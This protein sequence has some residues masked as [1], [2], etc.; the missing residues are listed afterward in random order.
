MPA[1]AKKASEGLADS[2]PPDLTA[3]LRKQDAALS[4]NLNG[5]KLGRKGRDTR[6]RILAAAAEILG[7][8]DDLPISMTS[9]ARRASLGMTSLYNYFSDL[10]ELMLAVL[11]PV[12]ETAHA[13]YLALLGEYWP[14]EHLHER[15]IEFVLAYHNFWARNSRLLH[16]RNSMADQF[17]ARMVEQRIASTQ[18]VIER[19]LR[20]MVGDD[21]NARAEA[22]STAAMVMIGVERSITIATDHRLGQIIGWNEL[23]D[24]HRFIRPGARLMELVIRDTRA[25]SANRG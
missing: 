11:D 12:M 7:A 4:H 24:E 2:V 13:D 22:G 6:E 25:R 10:T 14:D 15:C 3:A 9:V 16:L 5:Q 19:L 1:T 23:H 21:A 18:P 17:D 20:Q 8:P